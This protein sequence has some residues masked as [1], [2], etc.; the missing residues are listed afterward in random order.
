MT[1][2]RARSGQD[3]PALSRF[4]STMKTLPCLILAASLAVLGGCAHVRSARM[5]VPA[6]LASRS[7][8]LTLGDLGAGRRGELKVDGRQL[9]YER[10]ASRTELFS[11]YAKNSASL[12][13]RIDSAEPVECKLGRSEISVGSLTA[14]RPL[15]LQCTLASQAKLSITDPNEAPTRFEPKAVGELTLADGR[16]LQ[17]LAHHKL[18][19]SPFPLSKPAGFLIADQGRMLAAVD[20]TAGIAYLPKGDAALREVSLQTALALSLIW[21]PD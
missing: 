17:V 4:R 18:D 12:N 16:K 11:V 6:D 1:N 3:N 15:K 5:D 9:R 7:E 14:V 19:G 21:I 13:Y 2:R 8:S 20:T 10:S